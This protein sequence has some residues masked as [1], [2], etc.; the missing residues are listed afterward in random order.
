M[1]II[2][3]IEFNFIFCLKQ[4][5]L[6]LI[7]IVDKNFVC[8]TTLFLINFYLSRYRETN[9]QTFFNLANFLVSGTR[10]KIFQKQLIFGNSTMNIHVIQT[11][12]TS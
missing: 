12:N 4:Y 5:L 11:V 10:E 1:R 8:S 9:I 6:A 7:W 3:I 2:I